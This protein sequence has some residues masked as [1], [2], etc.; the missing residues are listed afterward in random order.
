SHAAN[1]TAIRN[2]GGPH[3]PAAESRSSCCA[4]H[5][6]FVEWRRLHS[7]ARRGRPAF[8]AQ[9]RSPDGA[10]H[11]GERPAGAFFFT[12]GFFQISARQSK[13]YS[14]SFMVRPFAD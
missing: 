1:N 13:I 8:P 9:N 14:D 3:Y 10:S 11:T 2:E 6:I 7:M 12:L 4:K 5:G